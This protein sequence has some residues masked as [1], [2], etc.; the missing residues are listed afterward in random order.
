MELSKGLAMIE[1]CAEGAAFQPQKGQRQNA[2]ASF[3]LAPPAHEF[4][5]RST[6][7]GTLPARKTRFH[8]DISK[9]QASGLPHLPSTRPGNG[10]Q[11]SNS[12]S[13]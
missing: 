13:T 1:S 2:M 8:L 7:R 12:K 6:S 5:T 11:G 10:P 9:G 4:E 3:K